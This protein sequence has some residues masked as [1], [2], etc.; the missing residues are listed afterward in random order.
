LI[1]V[2]EIHTYNGRKDFTGL[3][4]ITIDGQAT[5]D[6]DDALSIEETKDYYHLGIHIADVGH[7]IKNKMPL[8]RKPLLAEALFI[9]LIKRYRCCRNA[10]PTIYAA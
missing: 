2:H 7:F 3:P 5:L 6:F 9:C 1:R 8:I 4:V 10:L